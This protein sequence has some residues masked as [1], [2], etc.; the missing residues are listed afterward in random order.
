MNLLTLS[1]VVALS[2]FGRSNCDKNSKKDDCV[3]VIG[4]SSAGVSKAHATGLLQY[5]T[6]VFDSRHGWNRD[7]GTFTVKCSGVYSISF[8][9]YGDADAR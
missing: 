3:G 7:T 4:F 2:F 6:D 1:I 8:T 9:G 5:K